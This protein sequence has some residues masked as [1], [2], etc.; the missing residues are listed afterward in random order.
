M[1][2]NQRFCS[3][4]KPLFSNKSKAINTTVLHENGK[5]KKNY[6]KVSESLNILRA[7]QNH[8][9]LKKYTWRKSSK[10]LPW[11]FGHV[12]KTVWLET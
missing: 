3:P 7:W 9:N 1:P 5:K 2:D 12:E 11:L 6:K 8:F 10:F 4:V